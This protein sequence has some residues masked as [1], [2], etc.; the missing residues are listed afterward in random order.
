MNDK[1]KE[2][3]ILLYSMLG[4]KDLV[5][6]WWNTPNKGFDNKLPITVWG[7]NPDIVMSYL[8]TCAEGGW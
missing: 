2:A 5:Q 1:Y 3:Q 7:S 6:A 8:Y 4:D